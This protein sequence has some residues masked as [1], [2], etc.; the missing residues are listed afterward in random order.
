M[1][2][3]GMY[4]TV[5]EL[6]MAERAMGIEA[7]MLHPS[8]RNGGENYPVLDMLQVEKF[9]NDSPIPCP[10]CGGSGKNGVDPCGRCG[11]KGGIPRPIPK[12]P[13]DIYSSNGRF[14]CMA[15]Y[16][17][18][19]KEADIHIM[20]WKGDQMTEKLKPIIFAAH[21]SYPEYCL[22][23]ELYEGAQMGAPFT[24]TVQRTKEADI[25][26]AFHKRQEWF[27]K[28]LGFGDVRYIPF[29]VDLTRWRP[30]GSRIK[31][32]TGE[33]VVG[34]L[35]QWRNFKLP[36][37]FLHAI[38][39][40]ESYLPNIGMCVAGAESDPYLMNRL[41]SHLGIDHRFTPANSCMARVT[42][43]EHFYRAFDIFF[44]PVLTGESSRTGR[45]AMACGT[46]AINFR[47][48][49]D[50][51]AE[52]FFYRADLFDPVSIGECFCKLWD[53]M[54]DN[55]KAIRAT[56]RKR[57]IEHWDIRN[58]AQ[59]FVELIK[60]VLDRYDLDTPSLT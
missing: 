2:P 55:P 11:G 35:E 22:T 19:I 37:T 24:G 7:Q 12:F 47:T 57:A 29:G 36:D 18:A 34:Y 26:V 60:E 53:E 42:Y 13:S 14:L 31:D 45:E 27:L 49:K 8:A 6:I 39:Y 32:M 21:G 44:N 9:H 43:P 30:R 56:A 3:S 16:D 1:A 50:W 41:A 48:R 28:Q 46:P 40:A 54:K 52:P 23:T 58:T 10:E 4:E 25:T 17:W 5:K 33:P 20:H 38:K 15:N 51:D 59:Q